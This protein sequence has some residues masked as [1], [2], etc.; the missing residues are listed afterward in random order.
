MTTPRKPRDDAPGPSVLE[1]LDADGR[2][3]SEILRAYPRHRARRSD[4]PDRCREA[5]AVGRGKTRRCAV[6]EGEA[7][8]QHYANAEK[9]KRL[10]ALLTFLKH[11]GK[12]G[13]TSLLISERLRS[14]AVATDVSELR[15]NG[16]KIPCTYLRRT[17]E[18]RK[19]YLYVLKEA[20]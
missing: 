13:A 2:A 10:K 16:Y 15:R 14:P 6:G 19:V 20:R 1:L 8:S 7:V 4:P 9:S 12:W 5:A 18:G 11:Q 3:T 17:A